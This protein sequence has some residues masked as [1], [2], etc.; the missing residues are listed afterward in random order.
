MFVE[1]NNPIMFE[2]VNEKFLKRLTFK[3]SF[4]NLTNISFFS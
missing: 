2:N 3:Y 4:D 1:L